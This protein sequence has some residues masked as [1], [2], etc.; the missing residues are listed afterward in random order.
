MLN[1]I[2][3]AIA[4][5]A[6]FAALFFRSQSIKHQAKT[7]Q[8]SARADAAQSESSTHM[9]IDH[10]VQSVKQK[11]KQEQLDAQQS[12]ADGRRDHLDNTG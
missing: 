9:R 3:S 11:Q 8:Q 1:K 12:M 7:Q 5:L 10:A 4:V 2:L 6:S